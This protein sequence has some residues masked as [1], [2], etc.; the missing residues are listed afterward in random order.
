[1]PNTSSF[2]FRQASEKARRKKLKILNYI[3]WIFQILT[4][5]LHVQFTEKQ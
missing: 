4:K 5:N 2:E 1:M 3:F